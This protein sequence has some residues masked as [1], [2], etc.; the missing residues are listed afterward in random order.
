MAGKGRRHKEDT[1]LAH[2]GSNPRANHGIVNP[3][4]YHASTILSPTLAELRGRAQRRFEKGAYTYGR[5]GTPSATARYPPSSAA[6]EGGYRAVALASGLAAINAAI[7][8]FVKAGDHVLM[9]DSVYGPA[10]RFCEAFLK[11]FGVETTFYDPLIGAGIA[12]LIRDTTRVVYTESPGSLTFEM[13]DIPA[14]AAAAHAAGAVVLMDNTWSAGVYF[15]P[16][17]HGVDVSIQS[18]TKYIGGHSDLMLGTITSTEE[19]WRRVRQS[20]ADL[21]A[22]SGPDDMYLALRGL[23]TIKVR[24]ARHQE[25]GIM[26]AHW[27]AKRPE[28]A[29]VLHPALPHDPGHALWRRDFTGACGLFSVVLQPTTEAQLAAM[30]DGL[31]LY[32][33]GASWGGFES[34]ILPNDPS[35]SRTATKWTAPGPLVRIHAGLEDPEDLIADLERGFERLAHG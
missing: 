32:G 11:R 2:A 7:L 35:P 5:H 4:V 33:M 27:L 16:F 21:G 6:T 17:D 25:T 12:A 10:R 31:E 8:A 34:L 18:G 23:R 26:L 13:Q 28:V 14:I 15:K 19:H 22:P 3:P 9:V 20:A 30:V 24:M 29:R 1:V